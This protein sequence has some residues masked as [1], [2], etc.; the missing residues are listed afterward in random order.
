MSGCRFKTPSIWC[1]QVGWG[2][3]CA[4][5]AEDLLFRARKGKRI[6]APDLALTI[7]QALLCLQESGHLQNRDKLRHSENW[8]KYA[9]LRKMVLDLFSFW[10]SGQADHNLVICDPISSDTRYSTIPWRRY[11]DR[12]QYPVPSSPF[13]EIG[14]FGRPQGGIAAIVCDTLQNILR[15]VHSYNSLAVGGPIS[16]GPLRLL[17]FS[18]F[19]R[20]PNI[21]QLRVVCLSS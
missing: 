14:L 11:P 7:Q 21:L 5:W 2:C 12:I 4:L 13:A 19:C 8:R 6:A 15:Q 16:P 1:T 3:I 9:N 20:W 17:G 10:I 18:L